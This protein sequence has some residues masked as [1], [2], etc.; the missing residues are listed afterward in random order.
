MAYISS[1]MGK[2]IES[3]NLR[4]IIS[5]LTNSGDWHSLED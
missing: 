2:Y 1:C 4:R 3:T 5:S